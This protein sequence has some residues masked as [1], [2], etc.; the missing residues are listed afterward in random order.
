LKV[1]Q[2]SVKVYEIFVEDYNS[3]ISFIDRNYPFLKKSLIKLK[4]DTTGEISEYLANKSLCEIECKNF[5][6]YKDSESLKEK[7]ESKQEIKEKEV[8]VVENNSIKDISSKKS[9]VINRVIRAG[10]DINEDRDIII[11][12]RVNQGSSIKSSGNISIFSNCSGDIIC[13]GD[14]LII[15]KVENGN[16]IFNEI[17]LD[18]NKLNS[19]L[20]KIIY[21]N[22]QEIEIE[23]L[24]D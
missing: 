18:N 17:K 3:T 9:L 22:E 1:E 15:G 19:T 14:I 11:T 8:E 12:N 5:I 10:E 2:K 20:M 23:T 16:V 7:K 21:N 6:K 24:I 13:N 4:N